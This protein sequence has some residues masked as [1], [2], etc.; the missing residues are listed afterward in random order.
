[1]NLYLAQVSSRFGSVKDEIFKMKIKDINILESFYYNKNIERFKPIS[2]MVGG[3]LLDSGAF[4]FLNGSHK[5][6]IDWDKYIEEYAAFINKW[7]VDLFFEMD[8]DSIVGLQEV[9]RLRFKLTQLTGKKP[10]PVWHK[11]RGK[12]YFIRMCEEY[13]YVS[14][15]GIAIREIPRERYESVFPWF[16]NTAHKNGAKIHGLGYSSVKNLK[17]YH[18]DSVDSTTWLSGIR[19]GWMDKFNPQKVEMERIKKENS[20]IK[21]VM[22]TQNNFREWVKFSQYC[23]IHY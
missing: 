15:G 3:F 11:N 10:I 14:L 4:S 23:K 20:R 1:M 12:D 8:I 18:F 13:P 17:K 2:K 21:S 7:K 9:E 19:G 5:G 6:A 16:I 22:V